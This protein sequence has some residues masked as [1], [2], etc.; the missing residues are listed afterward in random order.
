M[1][2]PNLVR[3]TGRRGQA[4]ATAAAMLALLAA[5]GSPQGGGS[6]SAPAGHSAMPGA[7]APAASGTRQAGAGGESPSTAGSVSI[8]NDAFT[9]K[10]LTVKAGSTVTWT[11]DDEEPHTVTSDVNGPLRSP[12]LDTGAVYHFTFTAPGTYTYLCTIHPFM[13]GTVTVTP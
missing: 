13:H 4:I 12:G 3:R 9:P 7:G 8:K 11:N 6:A 2:I 10:I 5:C 1:R